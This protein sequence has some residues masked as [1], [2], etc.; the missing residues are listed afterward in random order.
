MRSIIHVC[1][2]GS[3]VR[4]SA[5]QTDPGDAGGFPV[6]VLVIALAA[7]IVVVLVAIVVVIIKKRSTERK[8]E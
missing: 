6:I 1:L 4:R 7:V 8:G 5:D 2:S 3:E